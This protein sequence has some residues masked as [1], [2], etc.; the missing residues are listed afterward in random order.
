MIELA[1]RLEFLALCV[2]ALVVVH[3]GLPAVLGLVRGRKPSIVA[4]CHPLEGLGNALFTDF[5]R[6]GEIESEWV[7][8]RRGEQNVDQR[9]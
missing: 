3:I 7:E 8:E 1:T 6:H 2:D 9:P 5:F 4:G